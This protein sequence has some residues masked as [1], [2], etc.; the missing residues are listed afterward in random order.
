MCVCMC[1][2]VGAWPEG[3]LGPIFSQLVFP[4]LNIGPHPNM[5]EGTRQRE[6]GFRFVPFFIVSTFSESRAPLL[7][8]VYY[9]ELLLFLFSPYFL[10]NA[11]C[12]LMF[13]AFFWCHRPAESK[14]GASTGH[15]E[16][17]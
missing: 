8:C 14:A 1:V 11:F 12:K 2:C 5:K 4:A 10:S 7:S 3:E 6:E 9:F 13:I 17:L 16:D 15:P